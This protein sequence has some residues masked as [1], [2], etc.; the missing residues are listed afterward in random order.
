M[1]SV[2][3]RI[4]NKQLVKFDKFYGDEAKKKGAD[5]ISA[6]LLESIEKWRIHYTEKCVV[7]KNFAI[8]EFTGGHPTHPQLVHFFALLRLKVL[9]DKWLH[10]DPRKSTLTKVRTSKPSK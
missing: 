3:V 1:Q 9:H 5:I 6:F 8:T 4:Y 2:L 10:A 7:E